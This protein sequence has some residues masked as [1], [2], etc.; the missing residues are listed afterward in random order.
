MSEW[1]QGVALRRFWEEAVL[2][3]VVCHVSPH[4]LS[5]NAYSGGGTG[6]LSYWQTPKAV[7]GTPHS[8][9]AEQLQQ[10]RWDTRGQRDASHGS[11]EVKVERG[12]TTWLQW[13][14]YVE[15]DIIGSGTLGQ[16]Q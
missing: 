9:C 4:P 13:G 2:A 10:Q 14:P 6:F 7:V 16:Q 8:A 15:G 11:V 5:L 1:A 3:H 12:C